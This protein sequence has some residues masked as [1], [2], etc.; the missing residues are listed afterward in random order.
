VLNGLKPD[1]QVLAARFDNLSEGTKATIVSS[2]AKLASS[3]PASAPV[4]D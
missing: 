4:R 3:A 1:A 2:K